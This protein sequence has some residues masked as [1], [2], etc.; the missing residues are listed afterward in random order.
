MTNIEHL[1]IARNGRLAIKRYRTRQPDIVF[2]LAETDLRGASLHGADLSGALL[3]QADLR[4]ANLSDADLTGADLREVDL[5]GTDLTGANLSGANLSWAELTGA[6]LSGADLTE[7]ILHGANLSGARLVQSNLFDSDLSAAN[8]TKANLMNAILAGADLS[9]A[10][11]SGAKLSGAILSQVCLEEAVIEKADLRNAGAGFFLDGNSLAGVR[12]S[13]RANDYWS[14]LR[15]IYTGH[16]GAIIL[17]LSLVSFLPQIYKVLHWELVLTTGEPQARWTIILGFSKDVFGLNLGFAFFMLTVA[18]LLYNG[19]RLFLTMTVLG[20]RYEE[21][22]SNHAPFKVEY[23]RIWIVHKWVLR[24]MMILALLSIVW[25]IGAFLLG[26][27]P[28]PPPV[29]P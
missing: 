12:F 7:A 29:E 1:Q 24:P 9:K 23:E 17:L 14:R 25:R 22:R 21:E 13:P 15:R 11:L 28:V 8:L 18:L 10:K 2:Q 6:N 3:S 19:L 27:V 5:N 16:R 4:E 26:E 20:L